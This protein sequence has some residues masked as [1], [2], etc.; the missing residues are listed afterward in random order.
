MAARSSK[1]ENSNVEDKPQFY[2]TRSMRRSVRNISNK[3]PKTEDF[4]THIKGNEQCK[5]CLQTQLEIVDIQP[6]AASECI[7]LTNEVLVNVYTDKMNVLQHNI[8][9]YSIYDLNKHLCAIDS[10]VIER[11][12]LFLT[13]CIKPV[14][15]D[16]SS[17]EGGV[18]VMEVGPILE[19]WLSWNDTDS[20][21]DILIGI[22]TEYADYVLFEPHPNYKKYM[23][24]VTK[25]IQL[26]KLV[27]LS[28][29]NNVD[30]DPTYE[31]VLNYVVNTVDKKTGKYFTE[32]DLITH[33]Q[34]VVDQVM[35]YDAGDT[36]Y[37]P[38]S[39]TQCIKTLTEL[40]GAVKSILPKKLQ[41]PGR[42]IKGIKTNSAK[43]ELSKATTTDLVKDVFENTFGAQLDD[44]KIDNKKNKKNKIVNAK[45]VFDY[46]CNLNIEEGVSGLNNSYASNT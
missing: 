36:H 22:C 3:I 27:I 2:E 18:A 31:D 33:A 20:D 25:K 9:N 44:D 40:S 37:L 1:D 41:I 16:M 28:M 8:T 46:L 12:K 10:G 26:S 6:T 24:Q 38:L 42:R 30:D 13:G 7:A 17:I 34:F 32:E 19:W 23:I 45:S 29:L 35:D 43:R 4:V 39:E 11:S 5:I 15:D 14:C 21:S